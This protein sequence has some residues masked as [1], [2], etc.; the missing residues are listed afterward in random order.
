MAP[1]PRRRAPGASSH[2][3]ATRSRRRRI[4]VGAEPTPPRPRGLRRRRGLRDSSARRRTHPPT[5][6]RSVPTD[7]LRGGDCRPQR[8]GGL[9]RHRRRN[10]ARTRSHAA[11]AR[12]ARPARV[13]S[14]GH[15]LRVARRRGVITLW[16]GWGVEIWPGNAYPLGATY[17]GSGTNF[18]LFSEVAE[19][20]ELCLFDADGSETRLDL[21]E[22][23]GFVWHVFL[24]GVEPGQRYGFRVHGPYDPAKGLRCNP[25]KLLI[26]P[27]AKAIDGVMTWDESHYGYH[28]GDPD[29]RNDDDSAPHMPKCVVVSPFFDWNVDRPPRRAY[30]DSVIYEAHVKGMTISHPE[31][32][33]ALRGTYA[34][35]AHPVM[36]EHLKELGVSAVE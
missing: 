26:D 3:L 21:P 2:R 17:D 5:A 33:Q 14:G 16:Q 24:P 7:P 11:D 19:R 34:G 15:P 13:C 22:V 27:Y 18:A 12:R 25:A 1:G 31:I 30:A 20:V 9:R 6:C 23:D 29:S 32:P 36:I 35:L 8:R 10:R 28:F 4:G